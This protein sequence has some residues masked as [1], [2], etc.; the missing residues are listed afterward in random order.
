[1]ASDDEFEVVDRGEV[2]ASEM[3]CHACGGGFADGTDIVQVEI[4]CPEH[5]NEFIHYHFEHMPMTLREISER[6]A[7]MQR[8]SEIAKLN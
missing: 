5:G 6:I 1:M 3:I 2:D 8:R 7:F 4:D